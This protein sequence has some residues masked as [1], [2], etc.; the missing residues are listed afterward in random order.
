MQVFESSLPAAPPPAPAADM[1]DAL[2]RQKLQDSYNTVLTSNPVAPM[3]LQGPSPTDL[4][5]GMGDY[6]VRTASVWAKLTE[7]FAAGEHVSQAVSDVCMRSE[8]RSHLAD[9][10][11]VVDLDITLEKLR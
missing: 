8:R 2:I 7:N 6:L 3:P 5:N 11:E 9:V 1:L 4:V 10:S